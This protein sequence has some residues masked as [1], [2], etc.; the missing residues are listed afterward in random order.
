MTKLVT[1]I[2][3]NYNSWVSLFVRIN[4]RHSSDL[5]RKAPADEMSGLQPVLFLAIGSHEMLTMNLWTDIGLCNDATGIV[6][7]FIYSN[8]VQ[9]PD[10]PVAVIVKFDDY[11]SPSISHNKSACVPIC[12]ITASTYSFTNDSVHERQQR[13]LKLAWAMTIHKRQGL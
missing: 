1:I 12:P 6:E 8:F 9:P 7:E 11:A 10:F 13:P 3:S 2:T 4:A 5:A